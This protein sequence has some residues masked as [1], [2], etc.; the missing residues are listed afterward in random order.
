MP[1]DD[2]D[3][4]LLVAGDVPIGAWQLFRLFWQVKYIPELDIHRIDQKI[5]SEPKEPGRP[6]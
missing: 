3:M 6:K 5:T 2:V 1:P 4:V